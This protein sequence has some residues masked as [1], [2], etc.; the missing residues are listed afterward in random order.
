MWSTCIGWLRLE[1]TGNGPG[2]QRQEV[3]TRTLQDADRCVVLSF[4]LTADDGTAPAR[5]Q[6]GG[7]GIGDKLARQ[8]ICIAGAL[9]EHVKSGMPALFA[10]QQPDDANG[11]QD[12]DA[13]IAGCTAVA[14]Q[15][16]LID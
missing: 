8:Q 10:G 15:P 9:A 14:Q 2:A 4:A 12:L 5:P 1:S 6:R 13:F 7:F 16:V 11:L 3:C